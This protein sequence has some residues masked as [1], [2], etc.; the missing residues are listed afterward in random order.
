MFTLIG[1]Y[2][3]DV[4]HFKFNSS[5]LI[6]SLDKLYPHRCPRVG[7][8][9]REIFMYAGKRELIDTLKWTLKQIEDE[10][11]CTLTQ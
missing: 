2:Y 1:D 6:E 8:T 11:V 5:E 3:M 7:D 4:K 10:E 9:E